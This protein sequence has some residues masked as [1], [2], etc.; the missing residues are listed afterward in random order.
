MWKCGY[1]N[2]GYELEG[3]EVFNHTYYTM[4]GERITTCP[5]CGHKCAE[6]I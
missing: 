5:L 3:R 4:E 6:V 1:G 2:C